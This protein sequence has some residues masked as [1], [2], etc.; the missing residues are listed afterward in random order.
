MLLA[1][2][3]LK[4][5]AIEASD[6]SIGTVADILF[7][8]QTWKL[9]WFV[10]ETGSWLSGRKVLLHPSAIRRPDY[11]RSELS[12]A[13]TKAQ[14]EAGPPLGE[15]EPVSQQMESRPYDYYEWDPY[16]GS[17]YFRSGAMASPLG[18]PPLF[19]TATQSVARES[20]PLEEEDPHLRSSGAVIGY[21]MHATD[22]AIGHVENF[23]IDDVGWEVR[24]LIVDTRN[25]WPGAHVLMAPFAVTSIDWSDRQIMLNVDRAKV[26]SSPPWIPEALMDQAGEK[27]LHNHYGWMGY[28]S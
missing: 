26:K 12:V 16:W 15:H 2:S 4:G 8:D 9:R 3:A 21:H 25:F 22:G 19:E 13:L 1:I 7:D 14:V 5:Y 28:G 18:T 23:L 27:R 17:A 24:Y 10:V 20:I 11:D 6:G